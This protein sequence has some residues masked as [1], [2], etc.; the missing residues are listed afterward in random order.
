VRKKDVVRVS[1]RYWI[2]P[3]KVIQDTK[4]G[5]EWYVGP[6]KNTTWDNAKAWVE[7]LKIAGGGWRMPSIEELKALYQFGKGSR[8]MD[9]V[10]ETTGS[11]VWSRKLKDSSSAWYVDFSYG[12][13]DC[14]DRSDARYHRVFAVRSR[15]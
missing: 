2:T 7:N 4:T 8:N 11:Y 6:D 5:L 13:E 14:C 15:R 10:F 9:P 3:D 1:G 12:R